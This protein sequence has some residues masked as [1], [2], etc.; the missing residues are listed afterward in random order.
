MFFSLVSRLVIRGIDI[1]RGIRATCGTRAMCAI[2]VVRE[3]CESCAICKT[4]VIPAIRVWNLAKV[5]FIA[6]FFCAIF[7]AILNAEPSAFELQ[8]GATKQDMQTLKGK[9]ESQSDKI[10]E[11]QNKIK[12]LETSL[13]GLKS[14][15]E[16]QAKNIND[17]TNKLNALDSEKPN[18][19]AIARLESQVANNTQNIQTLTESLKS[20]GDSIAQIKGLLGEIQQVEADKL[21]QA[22]EANA[23]AKVAFKKDKARRGEIFKEARRL[24]YSK[25]FDEAIA[26]YNW[27]I[28][29]DYQ[30]AESHY[31][32]GN[33]AYEK[34]KYNDAIYHYKESA[35]LDDKAKYMPRLLLN[36][37][38][39]LRVLDRAEDAKN[40]YN[41]LIAR[42]PNS[43]EAKDAKKQINKK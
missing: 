18:S 3:N 32:L 41:S 30:K 9:S 19:E 34:N 33:I 10:F 14:I 20:L 43:A 17:L 11:L 40:F 27:L 31:M 39:S 21:K 25:K 36:C 24:T 35:I 13:D 16:G 6:P 42:F 37:A 23:I 2:R 26:R 38:N 15:Y 5:V 8:S 28:E 12:S 7:V 1:R 4:C 29:I 22:E